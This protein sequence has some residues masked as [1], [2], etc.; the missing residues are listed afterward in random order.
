MSIVEKN[1]LPAPNSCYAG[2]S[3]FFLVIWAAFSYI[4][5]P[6]RTELLNK[7]QRG[8]HMKTPNDIWDE[9]GELPDEEVMQ[10]E[11]KVGNV[12]NHQPV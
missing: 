4:P 7:A 2:F 12:K 11:Q 10:L 5:I 6:K 3:R 8:R 1:F 9:L